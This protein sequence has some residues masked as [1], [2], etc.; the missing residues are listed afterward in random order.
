MYFLFTVHIYVLGADCVLDCRKRSL[1]DGS[2]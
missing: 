2:A 1:S